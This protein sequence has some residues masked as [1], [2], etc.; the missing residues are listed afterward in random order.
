[1]PVLPYLRQSGADGGAKK[2]VNQIS[3][4]IELC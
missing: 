2:P 4:K 3:V 1:M